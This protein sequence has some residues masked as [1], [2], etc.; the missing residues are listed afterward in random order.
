MG[1]TNGP[2]NKGGLGGGFEPGDLGTNSKDNWSPFEDYETY[3]T[4]PKDWKVRSLLNKHEPSSDELNYLLGLK[5]D[6]KDRRR[7]SYSDELL[8]YPTQDLNNLI[9]S[10][11]SESK[12]LNLDDLLVSLSAGGDQQTQPIIV[13]ALPVSGAQAIQHTFLDKVRARVSAQISKLLG[14]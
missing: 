3:E 4:L 11:E 13:D 6:I 1:A 14:R 12:P 8:N 2:D 7:H 5:K 9:N 10:K